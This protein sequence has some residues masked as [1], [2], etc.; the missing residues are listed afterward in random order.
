MT[1]LLTPWRDRQGRFSSLRLTAL[2]LVIAPGLLLS[3]ALATGAIGGNALKTAT[4]ETGEWAIRFLLLSLAVTPLIRV[5]RW[6]R[7][8]ILR[9]MLGLAAFAYVAAHFGLYIADLSG[10]LIKVAS[11]IWKRFYL[12]VG[13]VAVVG[14]TALA[15]TS[16]DRAIRSMGSARWR[17][18]HMA[19]YAL[20][21]LGIW[22]FFLQSKLDVTE[23]TLMAGFFFL[24]MGFRALS[25]ARVEPTPLALTGLAV[26][27]AGAT[28]AV[29]IG[30]FAATSDISLAAVWLS[31]FDFVFSIRPVWWVLGVG[32]A[33]AAL[34][35]LRGAKAP[36]RRRA[37]A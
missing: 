5:A 33:L 25:A 27:A 26:A 19:S 9:R 36:A 16:F 31:N 28:I 23:P 14:L 2:L 24:L 4:H 17:R 30:W 20:T 3:L 12:L 7:L 22:H 34:A 11:E 13:F 15:A 32:L 29:E 1:S 37:A 10:D 21:A 18:L 35:A 6:P 8:I